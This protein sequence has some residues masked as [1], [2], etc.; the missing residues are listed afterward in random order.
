MAKATKT[1]SDY[2]LTLELSREEAEM[3]LFILR[4]IGGSPEGKRGICDSINLALLKAGV[5]VVDADL[6]PL[7]SPFPCTRNSIYFT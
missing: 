4:Q 3:M 1:P 7:L 6:L 5:D 2:T